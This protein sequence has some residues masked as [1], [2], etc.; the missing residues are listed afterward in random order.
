MGQFHQKD[1]RYTSIIF[2]NTM[3]LVINTVLDGSGH[4]FVS[5]SLEPCMEVGLSFG[6]IYRL[7]AG[8]IACHV[9][10]LVGGKA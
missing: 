3:Q 6:E 1:H 2:T 10:L 7:F 5:L 4:F 9:C 8:V